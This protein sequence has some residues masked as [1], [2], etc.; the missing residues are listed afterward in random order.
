MKKHLTKRKG[1]WVLW[2]SRDAAKRGKSK[3]IICISTAI[4][5]IRFFLERGSFPNGYPGTRK[6]WTIEAERKEK[7][8]A[9]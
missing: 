3:H 1:I 9:R 7:T 8:N 4:H 5:R 6:D 2:E